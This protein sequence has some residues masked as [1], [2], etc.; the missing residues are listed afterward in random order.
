MKHFADLI[1][2]LNHFQDQL[3]WNEIIQT[4]KVYK[5]HKQLVVDFRLLKKHFNYSIP[6]NIETEL[7]SYP[8]AQKVEQLIED[9]W[10]K[11]AH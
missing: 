4:T 3:N 10:N 6:R 7:V 1:A 8:E 9:Y 2:F 11:S 5:L